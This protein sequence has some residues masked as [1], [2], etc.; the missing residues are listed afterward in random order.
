MGWC[1]S[2][3]GPVPSISSSGVITA[4]AAVV[5]CPNW[6][7][8][9]ASILYRPSFRGAVDLMFHEPSL[10]AWTVPSCVT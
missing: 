10:P 5:V 2:I 8:A 7:V 4:A 3:T 9:V 6:S 1:S